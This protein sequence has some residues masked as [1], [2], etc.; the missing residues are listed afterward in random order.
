[1]EY[2]GA[3]GTIVFDK[4]CHLLDW[5]KVVV[6]QNQFA[7][8]VA[9]DRL[10]G[11]SDEASEWIL[12]LEGRMA[13]MEDGYWALLTLG[14]EQVQILV[15]STQA[16]AALTMVTSAQQEKICGAEETIGLLRER[17]LTLEHMQ[18]NPI[19]VDDDSNEETAVSDGVELEME[20]NEVAIPIPP[21]GWLVPI[22]DV[23]QV[24]L[25]K[26]VSTQITFDL[27][28]EDQPPRYQ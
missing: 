22:E 25:D 18:D 28:K 13:D 11:R 14:Q 23:E 17:V 27:A 1:M 10:D 21:P 19:I 7:M 20:E 26:L 9:V 6:G 3:L 8:D 4:S 15:R 5:T 16:I 24:L 12:E 2:T